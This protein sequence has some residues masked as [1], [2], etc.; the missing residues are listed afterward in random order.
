LISANLFLFLLTSGLVAGLVDA[1][2]GGGG[3]I[4]VPALLFAG[5]PPQ[6]ALGTNK[7]QSVIGTAA[8]LFRFHRTDLLDR[9][10]AVSIFAPA[11]IA[12]SLGVLTISKFSNET[13]KP[14]V[15]ILLLTV[16]TILIFIPPKPRRE[17]RKVSTTLLILAL[18]AI[19][20]YDGFFGPGTGTFLI[21]ANVW[22]ANDRLDAASANAKVVNCASNLAALLTFIGKGLVLW[23]YVL[24]MAL[25]QICGGFIG[26]HL[27]IKKGPRI[28]RLLTVTISIV[29]A[30]KLG[31]QW[32]SS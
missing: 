14:I 12:S 7:G 25:G 21:L 26:A 30:L 2:A 4:A 27:T 29:L 10:R 11:L 19:A 17:H 3:L 31:W 16:A 13:L 5:L 23:H 15:V 22:L 8:A 6:F 1:I 32:L 28:V 20:F 18:S 9:K 24:P